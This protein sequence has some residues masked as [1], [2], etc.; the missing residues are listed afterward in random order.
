[1]VPQAI[2]GSGDFGPSRGAHSE[3]QP[4][5]AHDQAAD[6][7]AD[8]IP[9][10]ANVRK[11][12]DEDEGAD[13]GLEG[14]DAAQTHGHEGRS[15]QAEHRARSAPIVTASLSMTRVRN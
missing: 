10:T 8:G 6:V 15:H 14:V 7:A 3:I 13:A 1:M 5:R 2:S 9:G 12:V 11:E 4:P